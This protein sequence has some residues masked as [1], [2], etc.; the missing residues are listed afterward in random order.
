MACN[1]LSVNMRF[2]KSVSHLNPV[3]I[4]LDRLDNPEVVSSLE[5]IGV[6]CSCRAA[7]LH[8]DTAGATA[9]SPAQHQHIFA[10]FTQDAVLACLG[11]Q[12]LPTHHPHCASFDVER[13]QQH[14]NLIFD[15]LHQR[16]HRRSAVNEGVHAH[17]FQ[18]FDGSLVINYIEKLAP[19]RHVA[20]NKSC[21]GEMIPHAQEICRI[22]TDAGTCV[23]G[24]SALVF[25]GD[26]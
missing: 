13:Q 20:P 23:L 24:E 17:S 5:I 8:A 1:S 15:L 11:K 9:N 2:H 4:G 22:S 21:A 14:A 25:W 19:S 16:S 12:G 3:C 18:V 26:F 10:E 7:C 6:P